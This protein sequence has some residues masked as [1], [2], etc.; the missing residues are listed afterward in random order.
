MKKSVKIVQSDKRGQIVIPKSI[1]KN[2]NLEEG[3]AFWV[4]EVEDGIYLKKVETPSLKS[5]RKFEKFSGVN[6][7]HTLLTIKKQIKSE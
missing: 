5:T 4:Y 2:L 1:R 7:V 6:K 3:A